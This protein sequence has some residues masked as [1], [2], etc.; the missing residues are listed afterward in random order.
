MIIALLSAVHGASYHDSLRRRPW[1][2]S[3]ALDHSD[4]A[5]HVVLAALAGALVLWLTLPAEELTLLVEEGGPI[6]RPTAWFYLLAALAAWYLRTPTDDPRTTIALSGVLAAFGVRE[7]DLHKAWEGTSMLRASFFGGD[8]PLDVK[9]LMLLVLLLLARWGG[10]LLLR[11]AAGVVRGVARREPV[12]TSVAVF[13]V[14]LLLATVLDRSASVL[15]ER[16]DVHLGASVE[17]LLRGLEE[18]AELVLPLI[19]LLAM[20]QHRYLRP[21]A[22]PAAA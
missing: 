22:A 17:V 4:Y 16:F 11:H 7:L 21:L 15:G 1:L 14:T 18:V 5:V 19:A 2:R 20:C 3:L 8:A 13:V 6:E 9:L 10:Y 12:A